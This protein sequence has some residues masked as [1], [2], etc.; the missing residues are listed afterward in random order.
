MNGEGKGRGGGPWRTLRLQQREAG[1]LNKLVTA[2]NVQLRSTSS[3]AVRD[4]LVT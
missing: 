1:E 2:C 4:A 3:G